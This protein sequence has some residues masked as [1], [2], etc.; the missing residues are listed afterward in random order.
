MNHK[1]NQK[2]GV[3]ITLSFLSLIVLACTCSTLN[4]TG[5]TGGDDVTFDDVTT[6]APIPESYFDF[7]T[8]PIDLDDPTVGLADLSSYRAVLT[9]NF[10]GQR[11]GEAEQWSRTF[12]M[13]VSQQGTVF[14]QIVVTATGQANGEPLTGRYLAETAGSRYEQAEGA[15]CEATV[16]AEGKTPLAEIWEPA[17]MLS[18]LR[19]ADDSGPAEI[20]GLA[21][22]HY[23]FDARAQGLSGLG[24]GTGE[25]WVA[26][27][28]GYVLRYTF[29][30]DGSEEYFGEGEG[31]TG[32]LTW[33][34]QL[35]DI[36]LPVS[37]AIPEGCP[38]G[39]VDAPQM[40][41]AAEI[42]E[43]PGI[44]TYKTAAT[45][46]EVIAFYG[47]QLP[48]AGWELRSEPSASTDGGAA[49]FVRGESQL[50]ILAIPNDVGSITVWLM[51]EDRLAP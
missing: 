7:G 38:Y 5:G 48:G 9:L 47:E 42:D 37:L 14:H 20:N 32:T 36:N 1:H 50:T 31:V 6:P 3:V 43:I 39:R 17:R 21:A 11:N 2:I 34:Y 51:L 45:V 18:P 4:G 46:E 29:R 27:S 33:D 16:I 24:S 8:G 28:G 26:S 25:A 49:T 40:N 12:E 23:N 30:F 41:D 35:L 13:T 10:D 44:T 15:D 22:N 19:G